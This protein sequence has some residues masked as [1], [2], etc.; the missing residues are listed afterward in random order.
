MR[1]R[2]V[3][4]GLMLLTSSTMAQ[5]WLEVQHGDYPITIE[6]TGTIVSTDILRFAPPPARRWQTRISEL[7]REGQYVKEGDL[8]VRFE[9]S[10]EERRV[11][12]QREELE[13]KQGELEALIQ[14]HKQ[15]LET[16]KLN[17]ASAES[18]LDKARR[19]AN[20]PENLVASVD[21]QR[22]VEERNLAELLVQQLQERAK[23]SHE[24][25]QKRRQAL[26]TAVKRYQGMLEIAQSELDGF[27]IRASKAGLVVVGTDYQGDKLDLN[28]T[29]HP[30]I[31][32]VSIVDDTTFEV[33]A[34]VPEHESALLRVGQRVRMIADSIDGLELE[35]EIT[36]LGRTVR[37]KSRRSEE[38][39]RDFNVVLD[40]Q[41]EV[42]KLGV[43]LRV[44]VEIDVSED[45]IAIPIDS[46]SYRDGM[47]GI[48]SRRGWQSIELGAKSVDRVIVER[49]LNVGDEISL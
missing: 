35:G 33:E 23:V 12:E 47:P 5:E 6:T 27:T 2:I 37:R 24:L 40:E 28:S 44:I 13:V 16:E 41:P 48:Q 38:M 8:L 9:S 43:V 3:V 14:Q 25:R 11:R 15:E 20:Q 30:G 7:A 26:E 19:K 46:V 22:L 31:T 32:V 17:L 29:A 10:Y 39:I 34:M 49:G 21:Y 18:V 42:L 45:V 1:F 36:T 4:I